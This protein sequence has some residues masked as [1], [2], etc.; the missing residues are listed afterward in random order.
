MTLSKQDLSRY[1]IEIAL[2]RFA[3]KRAALL[4]PWIKPLV[5]FGHALSCGEKVS[6]PLT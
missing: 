2:A 4:V 5:P 3:C 6:F 1:K